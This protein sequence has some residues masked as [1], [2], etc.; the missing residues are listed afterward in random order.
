MIALYTKQLAPALAIGII[1]AASIATG[2]SQPSATITLI[3]SRLFAQVTDTGNLYTYGFLLIIGSLIILLGHTGGASAFAH[4][5][6]QKLKS[7]RMAETSSFLLSCT[8]FIDDYLSN[9]TVGH[10]M[11]PLTDTFLIPRAKLAFLVHSMTGPLVILAPISSWAAMI[12]SQLENAGISSMH[13]P[14]TKVLV[15]PFYVYLK[16]IPFIFYSLFLITS[17][18]FIIRQRVSFGPMKMHE[19]IAHNDKNLFGGKPAPAT[20]DI[21]KDNEKPGDLTDFLVPLVTLL[22]TVIGGIA[23]AG[24]YCLLGGDATFIQAVRN[25]QQPFL[26]FSSASLLTFVIS[27]LYAW[28]RKRVTLSAVPSIALQGSLL[29]LSPIVMVFLASTLGSMLTSDLHTGNYLAHL[30]I[31]NVSM[32]FLPCM[33]YVTS[34]IITI[35]TGS[36]WGTIALMLPIAIPMI[37]S[38]SGMSLPATPEHIYILYPVLGALFSGAV[39]GDHIS[40]ISE[41]TIMAASSSGCYAIDHVKTQ[42]PYALPATLYSFFAFIIAGHI[43]NYTQSIV[44]SLGIGISFCLFTLYILNKQKVS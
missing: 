34:L 23:Y 11:R 19:D 9:I 22:V 28:I 43:T 13:T 17:V 32:A 6:T 29:M 1:T 16:S 40:P 10:I 37:T 3:F 8:L 36:A 21:N 27:V 7:A 41:T 20:M 30:L 5:F 14:Y 44:I 15:D 33:F 35:A 12:V 4:L 38:M 42:F 31:G 26:V 24:N 18:I 2:I 25:N 39:C